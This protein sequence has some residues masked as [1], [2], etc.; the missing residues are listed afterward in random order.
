[1]IPEFRNV[2]AALHR[3]RR[4]IHQFIQIAETRFG[5]TMVSACSIRA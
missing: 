1:M 3:F 5:L 2:F 4:G